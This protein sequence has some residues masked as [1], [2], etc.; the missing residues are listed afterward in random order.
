M[1]K[2][3]GFSPFAFELKSETA[4]RAE[5]FLKKY[6]LN[7]DEPF[8]TLHLREKGFAF[9]DAPHHE[10][11]NQDVP[12]FYSAI[13][14]LLDQ[15]IKVV[16]IGHEKMTKLPE[17]SGLIDLASVQRPGEVDIF[18]T[19]KALFY[20]GNPSGPQSLAFQ[21]GTPVLITHVFPYTHMRQNQ[22]H[23]IQ[24]I[25]E[26]KTGEILTIT[27]LSKTDFRNATSPQALKR[28]GVSPQKIAPD[29]HL[30]SVKEMM[31]F[32]GG[33]KICELNHN[34]N[35]KKSLAGIPSDIYLTSSSLELL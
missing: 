23:Q 2:D 14:W 9:G 27:E 30:D 16:R 21:F 11:R 24:P 6:S 31:D 20:Y 17:K 15:G 19:A 25:R 8:V 22:L 26:E 13:D 7:L 3:S 35:K 5:K 32:L 34:S 10:F 18:L 33:G 29:R 28:H 12:S 4:D 1:L